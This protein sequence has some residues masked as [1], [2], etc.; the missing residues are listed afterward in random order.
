M[1]YRY[2]NNMCYG[3]YIDCTNEELQLT[4]KIKV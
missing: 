3:D 4:N 1:Y 2:D